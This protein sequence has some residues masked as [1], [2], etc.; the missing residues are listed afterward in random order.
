LFVVQKHAARRTHYDFRLEWGGT[1]LSWAV[2]YGPSL[3]PSQKRLAVHVEDHPVEYADFEGTIPAGNY[4][5]GAVIVWDRGRW[6]P[7]D[8][9]DA[10]EKTGKLHFVLHGYKLRGEWILIRTKRGPKDWLLYKKKDEW[11]RSGDSEFGEESVLSGLTVEELGEGKAPAAEMLAELARRKVPRREVDPSSLELMLCETAEKP[12]SSKDWLFELKYD[13]YRLIASRRGDGSAY[14]RYRNGQDVTAI[15]PEIARAI[16]ALPCGQAVLD[17]EAVVLDDTGHPDF[18]RLQARGQIRRPRDAEGAAVANP[19]TLVLFDLLEFEGHDLR[20]LPLIDRKALLRRLLPHA[21]PLRYADHVEARGE[22]LFERVREMGLEGLIAKKKDATYRAG[23]SNSCLKLVA[24]RTGDFVVCGYS[25]AKGARA[26][27]GALHVAAYDDPKR[28]VYC[29]RAGSGFTGR[30]LEELKAD[31]DALIRPT[32]PFV[33]PGP[34]GKGH[35]WVEPRLVAEVRYKT[36]TTDGLLRHPVF[37]RLRDDKRPE[38]CTLASL[39]GIRP[40]LS[41]DRAPADP[42]AK[43]S[44][45][46]RAVAEAKPAPKVRAPE[47]EPEH[48]VKYTNTNKVFWPQERYTKGDLLAYYGD[49]A[50]WMMPYLEDRPVVMTRY[51]DGIEGKSFYQKDAPTFLPDW[52]RRVPIWSKDT[53]KDIHYIVVDDEL[54]LRYLANLGTIPI[55]IWLSRAESLQQPDWCLLDLDPKG[56][57]FEHVIELARAIHELCDEIGLPCLPKTT[58]STGLHALI[59]LGK[60]CTYEQSRMLGNLLAKVI[61]DQHPAISTTARSISARGGKVY[62][63]FLQNRQGQLMVAPFCVRPLPGA[64]VSMPLEWKEVSSQLDNRAFT[65]KNALAR[66]EK[67][68]DPLAPVLK[69][70]PDLKGALARLAERVEE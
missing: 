67:H 55:H 53:E 61:H 40:T 50:R 42:P 59:P 22:E 7:I 16:K 21:G 57:P 18:G 51:P 43:S 65:I 10:Y 34:E 47:P 1:L 35:V 11:A 3:D 58:G 64:P 13:G 33:G 62:L 60:Q 37:S 54:V 29:G 46:R 63:D 56:A 52:I 17:G 38:E 9:P 6:E 44:A 39:P 49:V 25:P 20:G 31:L 5:A 70:K 45:S 23:R 36:W 68:G 66:L 28:L 24:E 14:L 41:A 27:F 19:V 15:F 48:T 69:L 30:Q 2:P 12:F 32:P 8:D 26:G 4:G